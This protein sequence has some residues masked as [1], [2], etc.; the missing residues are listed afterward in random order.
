MNRSLKKNGIRHE[1]YDPANGGS[2]NDPQGFVI[3]AI[4]VFYQKS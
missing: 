4:I 1:R 3:I 2:E